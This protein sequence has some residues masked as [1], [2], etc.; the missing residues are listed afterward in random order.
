MRYLK[1]HTVCVTSPK[2]VCTNSKCFVPKKQEFDAK[3][4]KH[5]SPFF[6]SFPSHW[7]YYYIPGTSYEVE[8]PNTL[9]KQKPT[10]RNT[11]SMTMG[12]SSRYLYW[13]LINDVFSLTNLFSSRI[14]LKSVTIY[15][16]CGRSQQSRA[17]SWAWRIMPVCQPQLPFLSFTWY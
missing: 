10:L 16:A 13:Y 5:R 17:A 7:L 2:L 4:R 3:K 9:A 8:L 6:P 1:C 14:S 12:T 11:I 15:I